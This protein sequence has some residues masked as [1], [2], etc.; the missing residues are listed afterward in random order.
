[1]SDGRVLVT[2]A[3][4]F[5]GRHAVA[6]LR[7]RG[8]EAVAASRADGVDLLAP[9][10]A[11]ELVRRVR[12]THLLHLAWYAEHGKF[13]TS[14]ENL[15]W[16]EASL[17]LLR[18]FAG[19]GGRRVVLAGTCAEYD[20]HPG[21]TLAEDAPI[22]PAT[23]YGAAKAGLFT[24][25]RAF[26]AQEGIGL[27]WGRIFFTFGPSEPAGRIVPA[28]ARALLAG[29]E[30]KVT[31]GRQVRDF[32]AVEELGDAFAALTAADGVE[33]PVNVASGRA[34]ELREVVDGVARAAGRP[35]LV[36]LGAIPAREGEPDTL[37][38]NVTRLRDEVGW[39]PREPLQD[40]LARAVDW[41]RAQRG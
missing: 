5:I 41:W 22:A 7:E 27:A 32:L 12:P 29:E 34:V 17:A 19:A 11:E 28:V 4:G 30:A 20:W 23:L 40:G 16:V 24:V 2:G 25:A 13:W 21:G 39:T 6:P 37:V 35:D 36:R 9:G 38:A 33:G 18:A 26:C 3:T 15:R 31:H 14:P 8:F 10:A 1:M